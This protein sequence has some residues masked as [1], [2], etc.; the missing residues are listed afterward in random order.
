MRDN[1]KKWSLTQKIDYVKGSYGGFNLNREDIASLP[2]D[3]REMRYELRVI[4][5]AVNVI[6]ELCK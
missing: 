3:Y 5:M 4:R 6:E 2:D 1:W